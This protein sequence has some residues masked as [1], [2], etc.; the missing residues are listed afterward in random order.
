VTGATTLDAPESNG[1]TTAGAFRRVFSFPVMLS[2]SLA[3]LAVLTVRSRFNDPDLWWHLRT[4]QI[5]WTGRSIPTTDLLSF[6]TGQHAWVPHEWL[7]QLGIYAAYKAGDYSGLML[8]FCAL[9][10]VLLVIQYVSCRLYSGNGK[11]A[12]LG[13]LATWFFA[14]TGLAIRPQLLGYLLLA[15]ELLILHLGRS[16]DRRWFFLLPFLFAL[17]VNAHGSFFFGI[18]VLVAWLICGSMN[19]NAGLLVSRPLRGRERRTL[20][21]ALGL[22]LLAL[23]ANP[24]GWSAI[25]YPLRTI[26]D[27]RMPLNAVSEWQSLSFDDVRA[28]GFV[29]LAAAILLISL[30]RRTVI[31]LDELLLLGMAFAMAVLHQRLL[32][33]WGIIAAPILS[34]QLADLWD[35]YKP[36]RDRT[37]LNAV[38]IGA[39]LT[40]AIVAFPAR[41]EVV[42]QIERGNPVHA[43]EFI[44]D[45]RL[46]GRMFNEYTY[47]GYLSWALPDQKV[48]IDGRADVY[49]WTGV[50]ADYGALVTLREDPRRILDRYS[51]DFCLLPRSAPLARVLAHLPEWSER[52]SD[53]QAVIFVRSG[54]SRSTVSWTHP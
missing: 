54:P 27:S 30:M 32:F 20:L 26:F 50:L 16:R 17:W 15:C 39:S 46:T 40:V 23:F 7:S 52:Y 35:N 12:F 36:E 43:V 11:V 21:W 51:V 37:V 8:L 10:S 9:T 34:R 4:G 6:T 3:A 2:A 22:S 13:A 29:G 31:Y 42:S 45:S 47:G 38:L 24:A 48:F 14:T 28:F 19:W 44:R 25:A 1:S 18:G 49:A 5:I 41:A 53:S 33:A